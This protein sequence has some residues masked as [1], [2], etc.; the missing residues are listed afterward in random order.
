MSI[1]CIILLL[2][3]IGNEISLKY[4]LN[5]IY[6]LYKI[7]VYNEYEKISKYNNLLL[8]I[9]ANRTWIHYNTVYFFVFIFIDWD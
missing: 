4:F 7:I 2:Q 6:N 5:W 9:D 8:F 1:M 3:K